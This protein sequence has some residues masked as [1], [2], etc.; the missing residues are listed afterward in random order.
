[1]L[2]IDIEVQIEHMNRLFNPFLL[3]IM[4]CLMDA[5]GGKFEIIWKA[6]GSRDFFLGLVNNQHGGPAVGNT[7]I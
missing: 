4:A 6:N 5:P 3:R 2:K 7:Y 1:M